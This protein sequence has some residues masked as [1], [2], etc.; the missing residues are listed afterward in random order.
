MKQFIEVMQ[1]HG[2]EMVASKAAHEV[3]I[4]IEL[5]NLNAEKI[6]NLVSG[7]IGVNWLHQDGRVIIFTSASDLNEA[8]QKI[9]Q[10]KFALEQ[11]I[12]MERSKLRKAQERRMKDDFSKVLISEFS[13]DQSTIQKII[14]QL[15][16]MT[17]TEGLHDGAGLNIVP[18][19]NPK[20]YNMETRSYTF[21]NRSFK[22]IMDTIC[23][24]FGLTWRA[25]QDAISIEPRH[26]QKQ[27]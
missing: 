3:S 16:F 13:V 22:H 20:L 10:E 4:N 17:T 12:R 6:L 23:A 5:R 11:Q 7:Q 9:F 8:N 2:V 25:G 26:H 24:D 21:R 15:S 1:S 19:F 18:L 27:H 14:E